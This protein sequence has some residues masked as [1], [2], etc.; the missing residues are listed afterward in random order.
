MPYFPST[1]PHLSNLISVLSPP[2]QRSD[3]IH[4]S[5]VASESAWELRAVLLL[6]LALLLTVPF[7]LSA[8]SSEE[9]STNLDIPTHE[10]LFSAPTPPLAVKV[11]LLALP[12]LSRPGKDGE[13]G[14]LIF[15]RL[16]AREDALVGLPGFL[17]W[18]S[19]A[20][21]EGER[22]QEA[23][24]V[25]SLFSFLG[26]LPGMAP[27][28]E[29]PL[30][31][32]FFEGSLIP[33]LAGSTT[34]AT[35]GLIRKLATKAHGRWW[36]A[37]LGAG[38][39][40]QPDAD[41]P[42]GIEEVLDDL[43]SALGDKDTI[44]RYSA[45]KYLARIAALLP[46]ELS[47]QIVSAVIELFAGSQDDPVIL[48]KNGTVVDPGGN[49]GGNGT[50]GLGGQETSRGEARWHGVCLAVAE[51]A[52]RGLFPAVAVDEAVPW[53]VK[54]LTFDLRRA[55]HSIGSNVRDAAAYVLWS[56]SRAAT[57]QQLKPFAELMATTLASVAVFDREVGVRRAASAAFQ[58]GVGRSGLY[59][60][61]IDV[62]GK[63]DFYSVSIRR[64]A[65]TEAAPAA[66]HHELYR[67][68]FR[69][70]LHNIT[71]RHWD[72]AMRSAGAA[73]LASLLELDQADVRD[74]CDRELAQITSFDSASNHGALLALARIA[75][76]L[77]DSGK[78]ELFGSLDRV[79]AGALVTSN[80]G[81]IINGACQLA[82]A[83]LTATVDLSPL[84]RF[85]SAATQRREADVH[86]SLA[87]LCH[88]MSIAQPEKSAEYVQRT[89]SELSAAR[90]TTRQ[91][92]A[93]CLGSY[94]YRIPMEASGP[95]EALLAQFGKESKADVETRRNAVQSL[96]RISG[97]KDERGAPL[98]RSPSEYSLCSDPSS[99]SG[100]RACS[101][102]VNGR[103]G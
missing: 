6:W 82:A 30:L 14:A 3:L 80:A 86:E 16:F 9:I 73:A 48:A 55:S 40:D 24:L 70:H 96:A 53:V 22:E 50:M 78:A 29:L 26:V 10:R 72:G 63:I 67:K 99:R 43:M 54:A 61:G 49:A 8:L 15:A 20:L 39:R 58:E 62:L 12:L 87:T 35:S 11:T 88:R 19:A 79:R 69:E 51:L 56:L 41:L 65:F 89:I 4:H 25:A 21:E 83:A 57:P 71:L 42:E 92:A 91:A 47:D 94:Q 90:A 76:M 17:K 97:M 46:S 27:Q 85:L 103:P 45:A 102:N 77:D 36:L 18:A 2:S 32:T 37:R 5:L 38:F 84:Q 44:V 31:R 81:D 64:K 100:V 23:N 28:K 34:S 68:A 75:S 98:R 33:H 93:L 52:R 60:E 7:S 59:P 101:S 13:Y 95:L 74:S 66:A 1:L